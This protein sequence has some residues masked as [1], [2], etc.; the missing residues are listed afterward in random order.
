MF[1]SQNGCHLLR[2]EF[3]H[4]PLPAWVG[5]DNRKVREVTNV[6][7]ALIQR[8]RVATL[9]SGLAQSQV[10]VPLLRMNL[11]EDQSQ[12]CGERSSSDYAA[13]QWRAKEL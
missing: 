5:P 12:F 8:L 4:I 6:D 9:T 13:V 1:K 3:R 2:S 11:G 10:S 7:K